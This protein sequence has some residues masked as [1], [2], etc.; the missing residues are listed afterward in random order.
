MIGNNYRKYL[1]IFWN[2]REGWSY[3]KIEIKKIIMGFTGDKLYPKTLQL[4]MVQALI[5]AFHS[6]KLTFQP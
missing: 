2:I 6:F 3:V 1:Y 4:C 5:L